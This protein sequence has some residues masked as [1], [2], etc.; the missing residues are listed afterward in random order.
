[1]IPLVSEVNKSNKEYSALLRKIRQ[2]VLVSLF[3]KKSIGKYGLIGITGVTLD[4]AAFSTFVHLSV[5]PILA[6]VISTSLGIGNNYVLN[7]RY[8]FK[9]NF[10]FTTGARF[11]TVGVVGLAVSAILLN[12][13]L[14]TGIEPIQGKL[15]TIPL[16]VFGQFTANKFW[17]FNQ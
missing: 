5:N 1:M 6:T 8:N 14:S 4:A 16:V 3:G 11:T 2:F 9:G 17:T 13:A 7:S 12:M 15:L 10:S